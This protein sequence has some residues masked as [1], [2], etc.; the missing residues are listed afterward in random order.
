MYWHFEVSFDQH[1]ET[2]KLV[3]LSF[4]SLDYATKDSIMTNGLT[5]ID[6]AKKCYLADQFQRTYLFMNIMGNI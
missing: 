5:L 2:L 3:F 6:L 1:V 4:I